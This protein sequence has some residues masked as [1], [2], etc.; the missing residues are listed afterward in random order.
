MSI[1]EGNRVKREIVMQAPK[2]KGEQRSFDSEE[3]M[4][5]DMLY[6]YSVNIYPNPTE[7][8]LKISILGL[9]DTDKCLLEVYTMQG[10]QIISERIKTD[11]I[12]INISSRP[13]GIYLLRIIINDKSTTWKI[14]KK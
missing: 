7:G 3:Q 8:T 12:G 1:A 10:A 2:A 11:N 13:G 4:F 9:K 14:I 6:Y 5:S